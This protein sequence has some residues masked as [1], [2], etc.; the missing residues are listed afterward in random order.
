M[1]RARTTA[2]EQGDWPRSPP[3]GTVSGVS[4]RRERPAPRRPDR[5]LRPRTVTGTAALVLALLGAVIVASSAFVDWASS[6]L[7]AQPGYAMDV[8]LRGRPSF[9]VEPTFAGQLAGVGVASA[10]GFTAVLADTSGVRA[11]RSAWP[12][13][14]LLVGIV[15]GVLA[16][17]AA[18]VA[19][20]VGERT[21]VLVGVAAAGVVALAVL[22]VAVVQVLDT[23][24]LPRADL[25]L[26]LGL[27]LGGYL[28]LF[29]AAL[30]ALGGTGALLAATRAARA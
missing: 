5:A 14:V 26:T 10:T 27:G 29:G 2:A 30:T 17:V 23:S 1:V 16:G 6:P 3:P 13:T 9:T 11:V 18:L 4:P 28:G 7:S 25:D 15:A 22:V 20:V 12:T 19:L 8:D 21:P 24:T